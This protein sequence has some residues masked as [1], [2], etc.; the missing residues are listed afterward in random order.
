[1]SRP[2]VLLNARLLDP[3]TG[4]DGQGGAADRRR[5]DR[6]A[7]PRRHRG[8]GTR[9]SRVIDAM[10]LC[11]APG[12]VDIASSWASLEPS[13][14]SGSTAV[15]R[16][17]PPAASPHGGPAQ[18]RPA[19]RR[20]GHGRVR[21]APG[22]A[23]EAGQGLPMPRSPSSWRAMSWRRSASSRRPGR[24][25]LPNGERAL[26]NARVMRR[27]LAYATGFDALI[28]Q[29]PE[30]PALAEHG[31]M[32][33][34]QLA[35]AWAWP[36]S[37]GR[38]DADGGARPAPAR[39]DRRPA[40]FRARLDGGCTRRDPR[41]QG[42]RPAGHLRHGPLPGAQ[43]ARGRRLPDLRQGL[44]AAALGGRPARRGRGAARRPSM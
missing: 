10:G 6:G 8:A 36:G 19:D 28:V 13:T 15:R 33:E 32:N 2:V 30:E 43:R 20:A 44:A 31:A 9:R 41:R 3:A 39:T 1:M 40:A 22:T 27:A 29:H 17:P 38:R 34:G 25:P 23:G 7:R 26:A 37:A 16:R 4:L 5:E 11:L 18:H 14:R 12:L 42:A 24:W 35:C 21:G